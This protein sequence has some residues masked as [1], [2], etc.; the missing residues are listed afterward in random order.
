MQM[1]C[2]KAKNVTAGSVAIGD[3]PGKASRVQFGV[4][5]VVGVFSLM[6]ILFM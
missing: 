6:A 2:L 4:W 3:V 1:S 5:G